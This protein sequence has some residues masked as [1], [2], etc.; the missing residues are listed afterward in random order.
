MDQVNSMHL[1]DYSNWSDLF[2]KINRTESIMSL[3]CD[4]SNHLMCT[5]SKAFV[6]FL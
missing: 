6:F 1:A 5:G 2:L 3:W 4:G